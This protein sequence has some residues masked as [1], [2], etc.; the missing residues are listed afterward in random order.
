MI[1]VLLFDWGNTLMVDDGRHGGPMR[2]WPSVAAC[3]F[4]REALAELRPRYSIALATNADDSWEEDVREALERVGLGALVGAIYCSNRIGAKKPASRFYEAILGDLGLP[5]GDV[6]MVGDSLENDV[7]APR[8][9]G[10][11][12][13]WYAP[14]A[15]RGRVPV[16]VRAYGDHREL[17]AI[18]DSLS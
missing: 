16:G 8:R 14:G 15:E 12:S 13:L 10:M 17:A 2:A 5:P 9:A 6:L 4:A 11:R 1:R 18:L 3:P 7:L